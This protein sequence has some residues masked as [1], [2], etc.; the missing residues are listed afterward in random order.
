[1]HQATNEMEAKA[2]IHQPREPR[3]IAKSTGRK[4]KE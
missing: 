2:N 3:K 4:I 1:M